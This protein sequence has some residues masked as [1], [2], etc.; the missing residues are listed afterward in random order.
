MPPEPLHILVL[1]DRDWTHPQGGGT[2]TNLYGQ[3]SRWVAWGHRVSV[4]ACS[5]PGALPHERLSDRLE[6]H[7]MGGRSTIFPRAIWKQ[8]RGLVPDADVVL[9]VINGV[10]FLT[11][12][13]LRKP[14]AALVHHVHRQHYVEE[15]GPKGRLAALLLETA[16]LSL[17][18]RGTRFLTISEATAEE[19]AA[20]G[21]PRDRVEVDY[22]GVELDR[23]RPGPRNPHPTLLFLGRLKRYKRI[24]AVLDVLDG[25]PDAVLDIA[26]DGDHREPLEAEI[27]R[28]GLGDRVRMHGH[29]GE[30]KKL[31]LLQRAWVN[32]TASSAEGWCLTV[33]EAAACGTPSAALA[34]G[35]LPESIEHERTGLLADSPEE[36]V[37]ATRRLVEDEELRERLGRQAHERARE[38]TWERTAQST[39]DR[40]REAQ[41]AGARERP[42]RE[43]LMKS[44]TGRAA[45]LAAAVMASNVLA[46][47]FTIA[48]ARI[49]G[50][51]GY[52]SL[53]RL[54]STFLILA[55]LGSA[56]QITV[57]REVSQATA[58]G[59]A[60]P[61]A[62]VRRWLRHVLLGSVAVTLAAFVLREPLADLI[63]VDEAWAAAATVPTGCAWL[64]LS[65][66]RGAL[67]GFQAYRIVGWS[68]VGEAG[69]RLVFGLVLV[70]FG[71]GV[72]GAFLGTGV[73]V[74]AMGI[75]LGVPLH[76]RLAQ[77]EGGRP[78][79]VRRLRDLLGR[80]W[81]PVA[82]LALIAILQNIDVIVVAH[83]LSED[84]ASSYAVAAVAAKAMIWIAIGLGLYLLPEAARRAKEG[85]DPRPILMR[86]LALIGTIA[87][88]MLLVYA[89]AAE[90]LLAAVFG[91]DLTDA[92]AALP[93]LAL[94]MT[95]LACA[96][97]GVQYLLA[98]DEWRFLPVLAAAAVLEPILL[99]GIG[100]E[101]TGI[102]LGLLGLQ[103]VVA[104][105]VV[106]IS[107]RRRVGTAP[108]ALAA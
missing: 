6:V 95:L 74:V 66:E 58:G 68:I 1:T 5:Y 41:R 34:V 35:G 65:I 37:G 20:H 13:W 73:S 89:V 33:M 103:L 44:D 98:L 23:Y 11:P 57:A 71:T 86:T 80:A 3:I 63:H 14:R 42:L 104:T 97:V 106:A 76:R 59:A 19:I 90:P 55:V 16:P 51:D 52:G 105:T 28:R 85:I 93:W 107:L 87:L 54:V 38:F 61:G 77:D 18:Y 75:L 94:A 9:E 56:L 29:V 8:W 92:A 50:S 36:L 67:Q 12:L 31:D 101:L 53:A 88:P 46:L 108:T 24:E 100:G 17:L 45:G 64:A 43:Q 47:L 2:G 72:T 91:P 21:I 83:S 7:R 60:Q 25:I 15:M 10:T 81:A 48:F 102:A 39:L 26:G 70:A 40:L 30:E 99:L 27:A 79:H 84:E 78:A 82:A 96:Y 62:G 32:L 69:A 49:L 22:I 4:I